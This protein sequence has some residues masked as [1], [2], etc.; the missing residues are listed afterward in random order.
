MV[1]KVNK[2]SRV[3]AHERQPT[4]Y[5]VKNFKFSCDFK[6]LFVPSCKFVIFKK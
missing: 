1:K 6:P 5:N 4:S 2:F 3:R